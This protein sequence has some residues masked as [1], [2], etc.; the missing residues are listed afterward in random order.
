MSAPSNSST[1]DT[2]RD[3]VLRSLSTGYTGQRATR[4]W[5]PP[6]RQPTA[7]DELIARHR[8]QHLSIPVGVVDLPYRMTQQPWSIKLTG[9]T[10]SLGV[11][12]A[13]KTG[14]STFMQT[15]VLSTAYLHN[16]REVQIFGLDF[17]SGKL[18]QLEALPHVLS[19]ATKTDVPRISRI[20]SELA[21]IGTRRQDIINAHRLGSWERYRQLRNQDPTH[22]AAADP[23][24]DI[25][26][27]LDGW[28]D[29]FS[30]T[31]VPAH[32]KNGH[33]KFVAAVE[34]I[35]RNGP[36]Q[37]I[38]TLIAC[39]RWG[40]LRNKYKD[41]LPLKIDLAPADINDTGI[42]N[43]AV[44]E[45]P[46]V[47]GRALSDDAE[48]AI[49][50]DG[51]SRVHQHIMLAA[52][53][54]DGQHT[55]DSIDDTHDTT[56]SII[57]DRWNA[58]PPPS[59][60]RLLPSKID[61][62]ELLAKHPTTPKDAHAQRW[63]IPIGLTES[64]IEPRHINLAETPNLLVFGETAS[65]KTT[66]ARA[67]AKAIT[68]QNSPD[69]VRFIVVSYSGQLY[70]AVPNEYLLGSG[71]PKV[72]PFIRNPIELETTLPHLLTGLASHRIPVDMTPAQS[73]QRAWWPT[74]YE[75]VI[76]ID[77]WHLVQPSLNYQFND[78]ASLNEYI[79][80][81]DT[82]VHLIATCL[83]AQMHT[84]TYA[85]QGAIVAAWNMGCPTLAL[86]GTQDDYPTKSFTITKRPQGQ[87]TYIR[88]KNQE[89]VVQIGYQQPAE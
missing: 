20:L 5:L 88:G 55:M 80:I 72:R 64:T 23:Y 66:T 44:R 78:L 82:G 24:G 25:L 38:H 48:Q 3:A 65:G 73:R 33:E 51:I 47:P 10:P 57:T 87:A 26:F 41:Y 35:L 68:S 54:L 67:I 71:N 1:T 63:T 61:I 52:P 74:P 77:D 8:P 59:K 16:P 9:T 36:N 56:I 14:K 85:G 58:T 70:N 81:P 49:A 18:I 84:L 46:K 28:D 89:D 40:V 13:T 6:L 43:R 76:L 27:I 22:P 11:G 86:S 62:T 19:I 21:A 34:G 17:S 15:V 12:G 31:W 50:Y 45:I 37:G 69:Q 60:L 53:R 83:S 79:Q 42:D 39:T 75:I 30:D 7:L 32:V 4:P 29:F 2:L